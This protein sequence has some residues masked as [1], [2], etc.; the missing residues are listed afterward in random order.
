V[1]VGAIT[2]SN[3]SVTLSGYTSSTNA[4]YYG[5]YSNAKD[6]LATNGSI[7]FQGAKINSSSAG[8]GYLVNA[9]AAL[10]GTTPAPIFATADAAN[11]A[12]ANTYGLY[13]TGKVTADTTNGY[14][15]IAAKTPYVS[16][17]MTSYGL[18]LLSTNQ[19]YSLTGANA[20][21]SLTA[22]IGTGSLSYTNANPLNIGSY[23]GI[24]G[25][26]AGSVTLTAGG[27]TDTA[28]AGIT[29]TNAS[30]VTINNA[31]NSYDF[32]GI[33]AGPV[34]LEHLHRWHID[35]RWYF[36]IGGEHRIWPAYQRT[37]WFRHGHGQWRC[38][39]FEWQNSGQP[40]EHYRHGFWDQ[41]RHHQLQHH[42]G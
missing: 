7:T 36:A 35:H 2:S 37:V 3:G 15:Q 19:N 24:V 18:A 14:I 6:V 33:I 8:S 25:I 27:L 22:N 16:G 32:S 29:V 34:W 39:R 40:L 11:M 31:A 4:G 1:N 30:T 28:D 10:D 9:A 5:I 20:V 21:A 42:G 12:M 13:W 17:V 23:N 41:W 26:T 38:I